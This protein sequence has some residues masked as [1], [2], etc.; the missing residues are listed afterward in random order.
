MPPKNL[1]S[2]LLL[3]LTLAAC[4]TSQ[5][6]AAPSPVMTIP[7]SSTVSPAAT[8]P[9]PTHTALPSQTPTPT[10]DAGA[11]STV[12]DTALDPPRISAS[13][14]KAIMQAGE[15]G[16]EFCLQLPDQ[17][18]WYPWDVLLMTDQ[19]EYSPDGSRI[20]PISATTAHKCFTF[21]F[22]VTP[23]PGT[24][25]R[26]SI[27]KV[28]LPPEVHQAENC[29]YAQSTLRAA[30]PGLDFACS[31]PGAWYSN[32]VLPAGMTREQADKLI[33]DAMSSSIYGPWVLEGSVP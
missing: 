29:A 19:Q 5:P 11:L 1:F 6:E 26:L 8:I 4:S 31:G 32:L 14:R 25:Y 13:L 33:L 27:G 21:S 16:V 10:P 7:D 20:D 18:Q 2:I 12:P 15:F 3:T 30:Y 17:R 23:P 28:E 9:F 22:P 24:A